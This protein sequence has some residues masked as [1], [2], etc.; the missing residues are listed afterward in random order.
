[1]PPPEARAQPAR[2]PTRARAAPAGAAAPAAAPAPAGAAAPAGV[3]AVTEEQL[4]QVIEEIYAS[5]PDEIDREVLEA[6]EWKYDP[7]TGNYSNEDPLTDVKEVKTKDQLQAELGGLLKDKFMKILKK[8]AYDVIRKK[9]IV[10]QERKGQE[11]QRELG[12]FVERGETL[13]Q[14]MKQAKE[15]LQAEMEKLLKESAK[16]K[17]E[18]GRQLTE[19]IRHL[20]GLIETQSATAAT[21]SSIQAMQTQ[22]L[23]MM[24]QCQ[25]ANQAVVQ[26]AQQAAQE[27][28]AQ[29]AAAAQEA[30]A[31]RAAA[32]QETA[33]VQQVAA[34]LQAAMTGLRA[35]FGAPPAAAPAAAAPAPGTF[36]HQETGWGP[37]VVPI[38]VDRSSGNEV[39]YISKDFI[40]DFLREKGIRLRPRDRQQQ[41]DILNEYFKGNNGIQA[42]GTGIGPGLCPNGYPYSHVGNGVWRCGGGA[43]AIQ[44]PQ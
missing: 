19:Q 7:N 35:T 9:N 11:Q 12:Q 18:Y 13:D 6:L 26:A 10:S 22:M 29:R 23:G 31:Q 4:L 8:K 21:T 5:S 36:S 25:Q 15:T 39:D 43:H 3:A 34:G 27:A 33:A 41:A 1:M 24:R 44:F 40:Q 16:N 14:E 38:T 37:R 32:A 17:S 2:A 30:A 42:A 20:Q 28:A